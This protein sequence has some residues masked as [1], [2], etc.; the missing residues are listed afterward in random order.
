MVDRCDSF[1]NN[2]D[3][4]PDSERERASVVLGVKK[5]LEVL[6]QDELIRD[7]EMLKDSFLSAMKVVLDDMAEDNPGT[8][9]TYRG[10]VIKSVE[11]LFADYVAGLKDGKSLPL[12][13]QK[14]FTDIFLDKF[15]D[16]DWTNNL[17]FLPGVSGRVGGIVDS[18][19][20]KNT[21]LIDRYKALQILSEKKR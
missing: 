1:G 12:W 19:V 2:E 4:I 13:N 9:R 8:I 6:S 17:A 20:K 11:L 21:D 5:N 15:V 7:L 10:D 18:F 14:A 16:Q 3:C